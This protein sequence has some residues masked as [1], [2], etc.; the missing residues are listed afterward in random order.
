M[1]VAVA[2]PAG[3]ALTAHAG[4]EAIEEIRQGAKQLKTTLQVA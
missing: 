3:G 4:D 1:P 2:P